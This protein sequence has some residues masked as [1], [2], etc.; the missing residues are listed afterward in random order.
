MQPPFRTAFRSARTA[1]L[2]AAATRPAAE[3]TARLEALAERLAARTT[4]AEPAFTARR[5]A[6]LQLRHRLLR[7]EAVHRR[8]RDLLRREAL[9]AADHPGVRRL[10]QRDRQA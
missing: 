3:P 1:R 7:L 2:E 4:A 10:G 5:R 9:D 6:A 8:H